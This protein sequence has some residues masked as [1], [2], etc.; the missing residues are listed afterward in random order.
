MLARLRKSAE[1]KDSGF[2]LIELLVVMIIIGILAAIAIPVFLN[3]RTR[4]VDS[5]MKSDARTVA[6]EVETYFVDR[7][8][9]VG[10]TNT[11]APAL[12][13]GNVLN[14]T[15]TEFTLNDY[16]F[17]ISRATGVQPGSQIWVFD[18]ARG[19]LQAAGTTTC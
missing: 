17:T 8:T 12:T 14:V 18:S 3:Q 9:Y 11:N 15:G 6:T 1:N 10:F 16:C 5:S 19:G 7:Q 4:A 2:T 13:T